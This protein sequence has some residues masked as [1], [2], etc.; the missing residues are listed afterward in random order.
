MVATT[1]TFT[2]DLST[3]VASAIADLIMAS[4]KG[5]GSKM[6][7]ATMLADKFGIDP[8]LRKGEFMGPAMAENATAKLPSFLR[9]RSPEVN[10]S[11]LARGQKSDSG[12]YGSS[13]I[14]PK[15]TNSQTMN[16]LA[17]Q[18]F[19]WVGVGSSLKNQTTP[20]PLTKQLS[21]QNLIGSKTFTGEK[22]KAVKV[23]DKK[24]GEFL[25]AVALSLSTSL[26]SVRKRLSETEQAVITVKEGVFTL[27]KQLELSEDVLENKLDQIIDVLRDQLFRDKRRDDKDEAKT[28]EESA[29]KKREDWSTQV[30]QKVAED[31]EE[32][33]DRFA[34]KEL[35]DY[36]DD[37]ASEQ[38]NLPINEGE[39]GSG[40]AK[41]GIASGPDSGYWAK[42]HGDELIT[43]LDNNFT[44][45][46][47]LATAQTPINMNFPKGDNSINMKPKM[48]NFNRS[49]GSNSSISMVDRSKS[50]VKAMELPIKVSGI[51]LMNLLGKSISKNPVFGQQA[52]NIRSIAEPIAG[53]FGVSN[54]ITNNVLTTASTK[55]EETKRREET[56]NYT[57]RGKNK[58]PWWESIADIFRR[59]D[60]PEQM[61]DKK[62]EETTT[63][64]DVIPSKT[65]EL[66]IVP[67]T[68]IIQKSASTTNNWFDGVK[69]WWNRGRNAR[70]PNE[71]MTRWFGKKGLIADDWKQRGKF[72]KGGKMGGWDITRG[73]RPGVPAS[74]GGMM[75]GPTPAIRQAI[76]RPLRA[77]RSLGSLKGGFMGLILNEL[78]NPAPLADGTLQGNMDTVSKF[79]N[80]ESNKIE[81]NNMV[82]EK[83]RT[84]NNSSKE[85]IF[86]KMEQSTV[87]LEP[88]VLNNQEEVN[89][90]M[91]SESIN[92]ISNV[93][94]PGLDDFYPR[95]Y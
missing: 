17:G 33:Q 60:P 62:K 19:P 20:S 77:I 11:Y 79:T 15:P 59:D 29:E 48:T 32:F 90:D 89:D 78:M 26:D 66:D 8:M 83:S 40:F 47:P 49:S 85:N 37:V 71:N 70:V 82:L 12:Y 91:G 3:S 92:H 86:S 34:E 50:M 6:A 51:A 94:D 69:N 39:D 58:K 52:S 87:N 2:G 75:S 44:Q 95:P 35:K 25:A 93:G 9:Y 72:G 16:R 84:L 38:D 88:I 27:H 4:K 81:T 67:K 30:S 53:A 55:E 45:G 18:P 31:E 10:P 43:P 7:Q 42:L 41:G 13:P 76:E 28:T 5:A 14:D 56:K 21:D 54:S 68:E 64:K 61:E 57:T 74:E 73:F 24:L 22:Q 23:H 1:T 63:K 46:Q 80:L 36:L 65:S